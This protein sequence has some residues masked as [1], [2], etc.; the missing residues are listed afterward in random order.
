[1]T[2]PRTPVAVATALA[3]LGAGAG[4]ALAVKPKVPSRSG[5]YDAVGGAPAF[6]PTATRS[7]T[8]R[9]I[10]PTR[11]RVAPSRTARLGPQLRP[12][13][14]YAGGPQVFLVL[15]ALRSADG[16]SWYKVLLPSRPNGSSGWVQGD[17]LQLRKN[18][19]RVRVS[20]SAR[21]AVLTRSGRVM[22]TWKV[23]VGRPVYPTP[24][25]Q[26]AIS[27][28]VP[29]AS[30]SGF[31]GP[32]ILTLTAHSNKLNDFD[33]GDGRVALHGTSRPDLLGT[34]A[35][36]GCVRLPNAAALRIAAVVPP[37]TPVEITA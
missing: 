15:D 9:L 4:A 30:P 31:Y 28:V 7:W 37:G 20:L 36:H 5:I 25:G 23:A 32:Y 27:E 6:R 33:G 10:A 18:T 34:A 17:L 19:W 22:N 26:F 11:L 1:M 29:Q 8:A 24:T 21:R 3:L 16:T 13:A 12:D 35:S 14:P 2:D